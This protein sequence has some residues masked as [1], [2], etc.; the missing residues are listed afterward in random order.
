[1]GPNLILAD[2][3]LQEAIAVAWNTVIAAQVVYMLNRT[4]G[5]IRRVQIRAQP[6]VSKMTDARVKNAVHAFTKVMAEVLQ[7]RSD[8][9]TDQAEAEEVVKMELERMVVGEAKWMGQRVATARL[10]NHSKH[11]R[12]A[13][14]TSEVVIMPLGRR[15]R[16]VIY[17]MVVV[18]V[19]SGNLE[20]DLH[21]TLIRVMIDF[22]VLRATSSLHGLMYSTKGL[23]LWFDVLIFIMP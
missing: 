8:I 17:T 15:A 16:A 18:R 14:V 21:V 5:C 10:W 22:M 1:V 2:R 9:I 19:E 12:T 3:Q 20:E 7:P 11:M 13:K 4:R 23:M 6:A